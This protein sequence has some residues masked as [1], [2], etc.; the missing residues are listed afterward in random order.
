[1]GSWRMDTKKAEI[2]DHL[3][4]TEFINY[5]R[6]E[7]YHGRIYK[8]VPPV[9]DVKWECKYKQRRDQDCPDWLT[10]TEYCDTKNVFDDKIKKLARLLRLSKK[11]VIYSGAG[12]S[13]SAGINQ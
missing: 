4:K 8:N 13:V 11:T 3:S 7:F 1:M 12:I 6:P 10:G 9:P 2:L 5:D